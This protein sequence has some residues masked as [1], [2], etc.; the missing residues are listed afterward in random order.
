MADQPALNAAQIQQVQTHLQKLLQDVNLRKWAIDVVLSHAGTRDI[1][2]IMK[3][4][5]QI[6]RFVAEPIEPTKEVA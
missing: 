6:Y 3:L 2:E 4:T 5:A 1:G